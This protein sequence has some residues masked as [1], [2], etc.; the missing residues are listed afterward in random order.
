MI[1]FDERGY[2]SCTI[3]DIA[4][5]AGTSRA[6]FYVH[7]AGKV[8]LIEG[9]WDA[10]RQG[11]VML[12]RELVRA[13][14]RDRRFIE[15]WLDRTFVFYEKNRLRLLAIHEAISLEGELAEV[16]YERTDELS[17]FIV[18]LLRERSALTEQEARCQAALLT[19]QHE[20]FCFLWILRGLPFDR[21]VVIPTM[22]RQWFEQLGTAGA[23]EH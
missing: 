6:T 15:S 22:G 16:Y 5:R 18:P 17:D 23:G 20:R 8:E 10:V 14:V 11:L 13:D 3:E 4:R 9:A 19:I 21:E 12:Y 1:E 2:A 7:F